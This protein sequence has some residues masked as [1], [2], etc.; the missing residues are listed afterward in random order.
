[1]KFLYSHRTR[2]ADGQWVHISAM[3]DALMARGHDIEICGP[4]LEP[5]DTRLLSAGGK[6]GLSTLL[7]A[8]LYECVEYGYSFPAHHR[9]LRTATSFAPDVLY[10]RYNLFFHAGV[11]LKRKLRLPMIL[12]VNAPLAFERAQ[13]GKLALKTF[14]KNSEAAIWRAADKLLPVTNVLADHLRAAGVAEDRIEV[15]QN[16][17][18]GD[19]LRAHDPSLIRERYGVSQKLVLGF[20]GFV[21]DWH[22]MDRVVRFLADHNKNDLYLLIV[23]DGPARASLEELANELGVMHQMA[24][25]GVVQRDAVAA[26]V[27]AFDVALQPAV[28]GYASPLKLFEYMAQGKAIIAPDQPNIR[29]V[30]TDGADALLCASDNFEAALARLIDDASLR[31][32]LGAA[33]RETLAA[34]DYTWAGNAKRVE[35]IAEQLRSERP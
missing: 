20:T 11:W 30:L 32:R 25:T 33:A 31:A 22:G 15:I 7:P 29:E 5:G 19:F 14:A 1:M 18:G 12:E 3:T 9:L 2:S 34:R 24:F 6:R 21:R 26:H 13:H 35:A 23:G 28:V 27:A 8:Q 10:E 16:G 17:V 4:G